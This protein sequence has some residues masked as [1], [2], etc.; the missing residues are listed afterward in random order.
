MPMPTD[1]D[2]RLARCTLEDR[3]VLR[4]R[5]DRLRALGNG[6][7][8][9][10]RWQH[11]EQDL[12]RS[13]AIFEHRRASVPAVSLPDHLPITAHADEIAAAIRRHP[14]VIVSGET[15]SGKSTQLPKLCLLAGRGV[16]G[17]IA[18]TQPRRVAARGVAR[19]LAHELGQPLGQSVG[20]KVRFDAQV[21]RESHVKVLT[22]GMLLAELG[23]DRHLRA[24]DTVIIDEAHERSLNIDFLL[25]YL[26]LLLARRPDLRVV[27][28]SATLDEERFAA[29]FD[30][31]PVVRVLGRSYPVAVRYRPPPAEQPLA[32]QVRAAVH[33]LVREGPGDVLVF[34][35]GEREIHDVAGRLRAAF[36]ATLDVLALYARLPLAKQERVFSV[37][38]RRRVVLATNVAETSLTVPGVRYVIDSGLVRIGRYSPG[39][40]VQRLPVEPISRAS[41]RQRAGRCGREAPGVCIRLYDAAAYEGFAE[42]T[43]AEITRTDLAAVLLQMRALGVAELAAFPFL[44]PPGRRHVSDGLRLLRELGAL[45]GEDRLTPLGRRLARLPLDPRVGRMLIAA[46]EHDCVAEVLVIAAGLAV[47]DPRERERGQRGPMPQH[48]RF[49]DPRSDFLRLLRIWDHVRAHARGAGIGALA[50]ICRKRRLSLPRIQEWREVHLQLCVAAREMGLHARAQPASYARIHRALLTGL[51]RHVGQ[52]RDEREYQGLRGNSFRISRGSGQSARRPRWVLA[53]EVVDAGSAVAHTV[54]AIRAQWVEQAAGALIRRSHFEAWWDAARGE[55]MVH[56]HS[57][58]Y[59]LTV[60]ASR[61]VRYAPISA[62]GAREVFI[63][64]ALVDGHMASDAPFLAANLELVRRRRAR[65]ARTRRPDPALSEQRVFEFYD[66]RVPAAVCDARDFESWWRRLDGAG[67]TRLELARVFAAGVLEHDGADE[68]ARRFPDHIHAAGMALALDYRFAPGEED[69]GVTVQLPRELLGGLRAGEL[70]WGVPGLREEKVIALLRVLPKAMRRRIG[71]APE[72]AAEFLAQADVRDGALAD[73]LARFLFRRF[74]VDV[75]DEPWSPAALA[76]RVPAYLNLRYRVLDAAGEVVAHGRDLDALQRRHAGGRAPSAAAVATGAYA[77]WS[78]GTLPEREQLERAGTR[79]WIHPALAAAGDDG[80]AVVDVEDPVHAARVHDTGLLRMVLAAE[81]LDAERLARRIDNRDRLCLLNTLVEFAPQADAIG[82]QPE[83]LAQPGEAALA[84][85][86]PCARLLA[87]VALFAVASAYLGEGGWAIRDETAFLRACRDGRTRLDAALH[88]QAMLVEQVLD[89]HRRVRARLDEDWPA[90]WQA[91]IDDAREQLR[92]LV[93]QGFVA[94]TPRQRLPELPRYLDALALR[95][96]KL[97]RGGARDGDKLQAVRPVWERFVA[98]ARAHAARGRRDA[99]LEHY[100][101]LT[102][103]FR[104][105]L[106]AQELGARERVSRPRLDRQWD[107]IPP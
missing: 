65:A 17:Q 35:S 10:P 31:A 76:S 85:R 75:G 45:D 15:G 86:A 77:R 89:A 61:S 53:A 90:T 41:A 103:E 84:P 18:H 71:P 38:A 70:D 40:A 4:R 66:A 28:S 37:H 69:D 97:R 73:A 58:L 56:E 5:V 83:R 20:F 87:D 94:G 1:L 3:A 60:A 96:D 24:Y 50:E 14:V 44:D 57:A 54:A 19:R 25:G 72:V 82:A 102:E 36:G 78:F 93:Y 80:V 51:L 98:R 95:L 16:A 100:R 67:L 33:E 32:E 63:R 104:I 64:G 59:A 52:R 101:W 22:D 6:A 13:E 46:G 43:E 49:E 81:G 99:A 12:R 39:N 9:D 62:A 48:L 21:R 92:W 106:F 74:A 88:A 2:A 91:S 29:F 105:S 42:F 107:A 26:K 11:L 30:A 79:G 7:G 68:F 47:G 27:V 55:P 8:A 34:L 23:G